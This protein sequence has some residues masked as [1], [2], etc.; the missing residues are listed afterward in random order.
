MTGSR[1]AQIASSSS[2]SA[3]RIWSIVAVSQS[4]GIDCVQLMR[5][6]RFTVVKRKSEFDY[7]RQRE[8]G[9]KRARSTAVWD[10]RYCSKEW[11]ENQMSVIP[12]DAVGADMTK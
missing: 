12:H 4:S 5:N 11:W 3:D 6:Y 10:P 9:R 7:E 8:D 1:I 2:G